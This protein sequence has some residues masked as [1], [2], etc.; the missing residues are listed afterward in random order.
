VWKVY[1][2]RVDF[3]GTDLRKPFYVIIWYFGS[4]F[5]FDNA[6]FTRYKIPHIDFNLL[7]S[8]H[9]EGDPYIAG[10]FISLEQLLND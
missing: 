8:F 9:A 3:L 10:F 2:R 4:A 6:H 1:T 5:Y 7:P